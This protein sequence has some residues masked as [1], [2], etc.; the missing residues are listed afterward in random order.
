MKIINLNTRRDSIEMKQP[1]MSV[2]EECFAN[3]RIQKARKL[4]ERRHRHKEYFLEKES[5]PK[6]RYCSFFENDDRSK[7]SRH[8]SC[9]TAP[10]EHS[11]RAKLEAKI[12]NS[13]RLQTTVRPI[14]VSEC[15][16]ALCQTVHSDREGKLNYDLIET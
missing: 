6:Q 3:Q 5:R 1:L 13:L 2:K 11:I 10:R 14:T 15:Q 12:V 9:T 8:L 16:S 4:H 7:N